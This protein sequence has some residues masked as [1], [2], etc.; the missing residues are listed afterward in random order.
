MTR[1]EVRRE[2]ERLERAF[3]FVQ[4]RLGLTL[5]ITLSPDA[6]ISL[7]SI[8]PSERGVEDPHCFIV[9]FNPDTV[10]ALSLAELRQSA[11]HEILHAWQYPF[12]QAATAALPKK[13]RDHVMERYWE[14]VVYEM[15][16][17]LSPWLL[18]R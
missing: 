13:V 1:A 3:A 2:K 7:L 5:D 4:R 8:G 14:P 17:K 6:G 10:H 16:R 11:F 12:W 18:G 15:E 9:G